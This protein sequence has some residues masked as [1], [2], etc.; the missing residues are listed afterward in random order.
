MINFDKNNQNNTRNLS[1]FSEYMEI[2]NILF[3]NER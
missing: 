3:K 1:F 2:L